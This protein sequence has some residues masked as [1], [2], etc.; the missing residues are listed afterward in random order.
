M[1]HYLA[2]DAGG[3]STRAVLAD[4]HTILAS[5]STGSVKLMRV[6]HVEATLRLTMMLADLA[7]A[8]RVPLNRITRTCIGLAGHS[9]PAARAWATDTLSTTVSGPL[10]LLGD[11][12]I[13]LDAAFPNRPG[14]L[15]IAGTG[16][17]VIG[18]AP[19]GSL[20]RAGGWGPVL[21]DEGAGYWIG[22]EALRAALRALDHSS[23]SSLDTP[24]R[25]SQVHLESVEAGEPSHAARSAETLLADIRQ[26]F[27]LTTLADLIE[28]GNRRGDATQ[29]AP[30]FASLAPVIARSASAGNPI[31]ADILHRAGEE[32][33][34]LV[35]LVTRK[36]QSIAAATP[37]GAETA[38]LSPLE[39]TIPVAFTGSILAEIPAVYLALE[40]RLS[41]TLPTT[42]L[43]SVPIDPLVGALY[44]ARHA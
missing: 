5:A 3:T 33:A 41:R 43:R 36:L 19:G 34:N 10:I 14:I 39:A 42:Q 22:L 38:S 31:A 2:I 40:A 17:N 27:N 8:A 20:H 18:R 44:R 1:P 6:A 23:L 11:E 21:G 9:I 13:A 30:D 15:L 37:A 16:S 4:E 26:H 32:L 24:S 35:T 28:L 25:E 29:S 7:I 12:E